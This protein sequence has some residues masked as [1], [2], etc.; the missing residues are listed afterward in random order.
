MK[1]SRFMIIAFAISSNLFAEQGIYVPPE[2]S[3][4]G[5]QRIVRMTLGDNDEAA[6]INIGPQ[7]P[8]VL[9]FPGNVSECNMSSSAF[10][11]KIASSSAGGEEGGKEEIFKEVVFSVSFKDLSDEDIA[12]LKKEPAAAVC[13]HEDLGKVYYREI[14]LR[15]NETRP[16][17]V[18]FFENPQRK[19]KKVDLD[20]VKGLQFIKI[21]NGEYQFLVKKDK[22]EEAGGTVKR[23]K[24][25]DG[26][27][28]EGK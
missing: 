21:E 5:N 20:R 19:G 25:K 14:L 12:T 18:V 13:K 6:V 2:K 24:I 16:H 22:N 26:K 3:L 27:V 23:F 9:V 11:W 10:S 8:V 4:R 1:F 28:V 7:G 17:R 15:V